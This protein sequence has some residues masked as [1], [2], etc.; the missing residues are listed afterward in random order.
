MKHV[1]TGTQKVE[2]ELQELF[3]EYRHPADGRRH[4]RPADT[5]RS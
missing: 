3:P 5:S 1:G 4:R 2:E